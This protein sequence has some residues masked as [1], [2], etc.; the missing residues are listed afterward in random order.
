MMINK[1]FVLSVSLLILG[2]L[3]SSAQAS[4]Y[5]DAFYA[6]C[7]DGVQKAPSLQDAIKQYPN[8]ADVNCACGTNKLK[9]QY[10]SDDVA[11]LA[12]NDG[13]TATLNEADKSRKDKL[14]NMAYT[15]GGDC[16]EEFVKTHPIKSNNN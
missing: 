10:T 7:V 15:V 8:F 14:D 5:F 4:D 13:K 16:V 2:G 6:D 9:T 1:S 12:L 11:F 3:C